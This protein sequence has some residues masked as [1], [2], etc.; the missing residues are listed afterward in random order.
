MKISPD[1]I[2]WTLLE[3]CNT[4]LRVLRHIGA[5]EEFQYASSAFLA[6]LSNTAYRAA[7]STAKEE[8]FPETYIVQPP[9]CWVKEKCQICKYQINCITSLLNLPCRALILF[10]LFDNSS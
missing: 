8:A 10:G 3:A 9:S 4:R 1:E 2:D 6:C 5:D 7:D